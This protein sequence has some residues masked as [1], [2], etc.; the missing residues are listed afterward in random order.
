MTNI[1]FIVVG[2]HYSY[3]EWTNGLIE[4]NSQ[5]ENI[6][7][8][9][10]CHREPTDIVKENFNWKLFKNIGLEEGA[11][12]QAVEYL[13]LDDD[14]IL[15]LVHDDLIIKDWDFI[16]VCV[17]ALEE[18]KVLGNGINYPAL[19]DPEKIEMNEKKNI[20]WVSPDWRYLFTEPIVGSTVRSSFLVIKLKDLKRVG[21]F[22]PIWL[23][24]KLDE[25]GEGVDYGGIGNLGQT[26]VGCKFTKIFGKDNIGY[27]SDTYLNSKYIYECARGNVTKEFYK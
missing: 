3:P 13:D 4:L 22:N 16:N 9:W 2:W 1:Q 24:P 20:E 19:F 7:V 14:T 17:N 10:S 18:Y 8:F 23:T 5:N 21:G 12:T 11:Y 25:D 15:F 6:D 27:L 26:I